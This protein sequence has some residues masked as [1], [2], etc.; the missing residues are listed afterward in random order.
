MSDK[1]KP[2]FHQLRIMHGMML[3][4][5]I[6]FLGIVRFIILDN[7][8]IEN[9][10]TEEQWLLYLSAAA[11]VAGLFSGWVVFKNRIKESENIDLNTRLGNY[12]AALIVRWALLEAPVLF[13]IALFL[14]YADKYFM[15]VAL[16]GMALFAFLRP[17]PEKCVVHLNLNEADAR[18]INEM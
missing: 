15:G 12:R 11:L 18:A 7:A 1:P 16:V 10:K 2:F 14:I 6:A 8:E 13:A 17:A 5:M 9:A 4:G 3:L